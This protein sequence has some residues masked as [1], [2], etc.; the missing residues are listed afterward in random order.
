[1]ARN[2]SDTEAFWAAMSSGGVAVVRGP[3][4]VQHVT[5]VVIFAEGRRGPSRIICERRNGGV[6]VRIDGVDFRLIPWDGVERLCDAL[7]AM[8]DGE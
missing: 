5:G 6:M 8:V 4:V 1:M 3:T 7:G 2:K